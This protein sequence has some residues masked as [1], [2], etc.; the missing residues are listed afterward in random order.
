MPVYEVLRKPFFTKD[1][2]VQVGDTVELPA[3]AGDAQPNS[4]KRLDL[5][6]VSDP[7]PPLILDAPAA[8]ETPLAV[9][10]EAL[11]DDVLKLLAGANF[12]SVEQ[13]QATSDADLRKIKGIG[14]ATIKKIREAIYAD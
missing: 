7:H 9:L 11:G 10:G 13:L 2:P 4:L 14:N 1:G 8:D 3:S 5:L 6:P 12:A